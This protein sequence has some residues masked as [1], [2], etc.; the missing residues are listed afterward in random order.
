[1]DKSK[2]KAE[3]TYLSPVHEPQKLTSYLKREWRVL[4][5]VVLTGLAFDG[6]MSVIAI[7][8]GKLIDAVVDKVSI[9]ILLSKALMFV[10]IVTLIQITRAAKRYSVRLFANRVGAAMRRMF[11]YG[12]LSRS[13][14]E[15]SGV[16]AGDMMTR[17][18][19]DVDIC[20]EGMRKVTTEIFDTG[21]LMIGYFITMLTYD[22]RISVIGCLFIPLAMFVAEK[23]KTVIERFTRLSRQQSGVVSELTLS[24]AENAM[25]YRAYSVTE[26]KNAEYDEKLAE[27]EK[28]SIRADVLENSMQPIYNVIALTGILGILI[29]GGGKVAGGA[30]T[31][32]DFTAYIAIFVSLATKA[33]K[34]AKLFNTYQKAATSWK[35][36]RPVFV[37]Y[38]PPKEAETYEG[39]DVSLTCRDLGFSYTDEC[40]AIFGGLD[41]DAEAGEIIGVTGKIASGKTALGLALTGVYPYT[42]SLILCGRELRDIPQSERSGLISYMGHDPQLVTDTISENIALGDKGDVRAALRDV[43]FEEDLLSM[44]EGENTLVGAGGI[45]LSGGQRA[46]VALSRT[47]FRAGKLI[48]LDDPFSAVDMKT[49]AIILDDLK[50]RCSDSIIV[51]ISHRL[52]VFDRTD[53]V[54]YLED[55]RA[56]CSTHER[57]LEANP[58]YRALWASQTGGEL[59]G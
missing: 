10:G 1:M 15:L 7:L 53:K 44:P 25:L 9:D 6:S 59:N 20:V 30:W 39:K 17:T 34:A 14:P 51:L 33:S 22:L 2:S 13:L 36:I 4:L 24:G 43:C 27:L 58:E 52:S 35:R 40:G 56:G 16:S 54:V 5:I 21:V 11:Y 31:I 50:K 45:R 55:G 3:N 8:Q 47:V 26:L 29:L 57:L 32:G 48:I 23:L 41:F 42:G 38:V 37:D 19:G 18:V 49:E 12:K 28:R 46:R